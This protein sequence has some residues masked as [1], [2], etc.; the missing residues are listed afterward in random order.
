[1]Q[2]EDVLPMSQIWDDMPKKGSWDNNTVHT[3][4]V[5]FIGFV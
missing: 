3:T 4:N 5:Q 2:A 1:M